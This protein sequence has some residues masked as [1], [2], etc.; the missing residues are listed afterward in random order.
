MAERRIVVRTDE[1]APDASKNA[2]ALRAR[3][4]AHA[5]VVD[6]DRLRPP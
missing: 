4:R 1:R 6:E 2:T 3:F 5:A